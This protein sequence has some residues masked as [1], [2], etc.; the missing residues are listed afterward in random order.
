MKAH[1]GGKIGGR[2]SGFD[3]RPPSV[4]IFPAAT[5]LPFRPWFEI[6]LQFDF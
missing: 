2:W 4:G 3:P 6:S 1:L 5:S